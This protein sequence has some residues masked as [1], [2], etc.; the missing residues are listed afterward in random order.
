MT[1]A[2]FLPWSVLSWAGAA[3]GLQVAGHGGG[4]AGLSMRELQIQ[5]TTANRLSQTLFWPRAASLCPRLPL[6]PVL[7]VLPFAP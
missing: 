5:P 1:R 6:P 2:V 7:G 3:R 4:L